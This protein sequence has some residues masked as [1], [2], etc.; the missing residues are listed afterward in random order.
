MICRR[1]RRRCRWRR[2]LRI[3]RLFDFPDD[4]EGLDVVVDQ[5]RVTVS[6]AVR[7]VSRFDLVSLF[8][9]VQGRFGDVNPAADE[10]KLSRR[11]FLIVKNA[12]RT[13]WTLTLSVPR[14][15]PPHSPPPPHPPPPTQLDV[16][17]LTWDTKGQLRSQPSI[18]SLHGH[19]LS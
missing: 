15:R 3:R 14:Q 13:K 19:I 6:L 16:A 2:R 4:E 1:R 18:C 9:V 11:A 5:E 8:Q 7:R 17:L 12:F 10:V